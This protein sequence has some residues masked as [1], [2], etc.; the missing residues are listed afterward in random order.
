MTSSLE[1]LER[2]LL[3]AGGTGLLGQYYG[4]A[5]LGDLSLVRTDATVNY[6]WGSGSPDP[7]VPAGAYSVRWSGRVEPLYTE[8]YTFSVLHDHGA[9]LWVDGQQVVNAWG[10]S[11]SGP[12]ED[13]GALRLVAGRRYDIVLEYSESGGNSQVQLSWAS[14]TQAK[15]VIPQS[16]LFP[17]ER[18]SITQEYWTNL[19]GSN[20]S[21]LT[22]ASVYPNSPTGGTTLSSMEAP[23]NFGDNFGQRIVGYISPPQTGIY[24][25]YVAGDD[26]AAL[27]LSTDA[28]AANKRLVATA[29]SATAP[30]EWTKFPQQRSTGVRLQAGQR[31]YIEAVGKDAAGA[32]HL[33]A[34][35]TLPDGSFAG[36]IDGQFLEPLLPEVRLTATQSNVYEGSSAQGIFTVTRTKGSNAQPLTVNYSVTGTA[37]AGADYAPLSGSVTIAA[38]AS[39]ADVNITALD[40]SNVEPL[41]NVTLTLSDSSGY[42]LGPV[43]S[44]SGSLQIYDDDTTATGGTSVISDGLTGFTLQGNNTYGTKS[45]VNVSDPPIIYVGG[46]PTPAFT[47]AIQ[48]VTTTQP[49]KPQNLQLN[50]VNSA[51]I[52]QSDTLYVELYARAVGSSTSAQ[53]TVIFEQKVTFTQS[54]NY[55]ATVGTQWQKLQLPFS[56]LG[57]YIAGNAQLNLRL[58]FAPQTIQ[59]GGIKVLNYG[60]SVPPGSLPQTKTPLSYGGRQAN[61][62]WRD[63]AQQRIDQLR[64]GNLTVHVFDAAGKPVDGATV[65]LRQ[66]QQ[67]FKFGSAVNATRLTT[68]TP[69]G[70][71]LKYRAA[72]LRIFNKVV[73]ENDLKWPQWRSTTGRQRAID[74]VNWAVANGLKVRGHNLIWPRWQSI[75]ST[76]GASSGTYNGVSWSADA[77]T[78]ASQA[79]YNA[80]V[81][82]DGLAAAQAWMADR[83]LTHITDE[84]STLAGKPAEW[85][86]D[87]EPF[88][89]TDIQ[90]AY[91]STGVLTNA[92]M[93]DWYN[94]AHAAD[95][96]ATLFINDY[97]IFSN[98]GQN[99]SHIA[100]YKN[101]IQYLIANG[102]ALGG[103][104][105]QGHYD[106]SRLSDIDKLQPV[107]DQFASYGLRLETTEYD[108]DTADLQVQADYM[109]DYLTM[110]FS[111]PSMNSFML[112]GFWEGQQNK[113]QSALY[114]ADWSIKPNGQQ[115]EDLIFGDWWW[116]LTGTTAAGQ[117]ATRAETGTY[118]VT[119]SFGGETRTVQAS[120][121][122]TGATTNVMLLNT[123]VPDAPGSLLASGSPQ[124]VDLS[125]TDAAMNET[126]YSVERSADGL[127][128]TEI[129]ALPANSTSYSD[130]S[131]TL[132]TAYTYRVRAIGAD[133]STSSDY[134]PLAAAT[135]GATP[136]S[137]VA[138]VSRRT[139]GANGPTFDAVL[140]LVGNSGIESRSTTSGWSMVLTFDKP[141]AQVGTITLSGTSGTAGTA[142]ISGNTI[143]VPITGAVNLE[144]V[145]LTASNIQATDGTTLPSASAT[146]RLIK[147]D[148][149]GDGQVNIS[150][151][152][153]VRSQS[154]QALNLGIFRR[155]INADG[156]INISDISIVRSLSGTILGAKT[157]DNA[158]TLTQPA[159]QVTSQGQAIPPIAFTIG[160]VET[161]ANALFLTV[162]SNNEDL[163]P[164]DTAYSFGGSGTSRT[165]TITPAAGMTGTATI[166]LSVSDGQTFTRKTFTLMVNSSVAAPQLNLLDGADV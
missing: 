80:H 166:T 98:N 101:W 81:T 163:L 36:P 45:T 118:D 64:R 47:Q 105:E 152:N 84:A 135:A 20:V 150:D 106:E 96:N 1:A 119:V 97:Q 25:F 6:Q 99:A 79:E 57:S 111:Q 33:A 126:G 35:W 141:I 112:W 142:V 88:T 43:S 94:A 86:V 34:A 38:G 66:S 165:L 113:P 3:F 114:N 2:R 50:Q 60:T 27:Y 74:G 122:T 109:R 140:P 107:I 22:S 87:N 39:S 10:N 108:F 18:G 104:G 161:T 8:T 61:A 117:F 71:D 26:S 12:T 49:P 65:A 139:H 158:P 53:T 146:V 63:G 89:S 143:S 82:A 91:G 93:I 148:V 159:D 136:P 30:H 16:Q 102:V 145:T 92:A 144:T 42:V 52:N 67:A 164:I 29:P 162:T 15:E 127:R 23:Q 7:T 90:G 73:F 51:A 56:A 31:Y 132:G 155:D 21:D 68:A 83:I 54:L 19:P 129:A 28:Q 128:F 125:W 157:G 138:A 24:T 75:P 11:G 149:N 32:D 153:L 69:S 59:L 156:Q 154:G 77:T 160:D 100:N 133:P 130:A 76:T 62:A 9:R 95:P 4:T 116:D 103:I 121:D 5:Q 40:N 85:D 41:E 48:V 151:I 78:Q 70:D 120:L 14:P 134:S 17:A 13:S 58:G 110:M 44:R 37:T 115:W 124:G 123:I 131:A 137:L 72:I 55:T 147:G 46:N